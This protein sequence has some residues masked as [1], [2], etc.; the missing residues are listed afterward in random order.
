MITLFWPNIFQKEDLNY[1]KCISILYKLTEKY[2]YDSF[3]TLFY[4]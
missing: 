1:E 4:F 2:S 3:A